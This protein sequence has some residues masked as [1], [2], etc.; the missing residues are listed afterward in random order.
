[1]DEAIALYQ[2]AARAGLEW[3]GLAAVFVVLSIR[4][5]RTDVAQGLLPA[6]FQW[7]RLK[8]WA[9]LL[10]IF[11]AA[12]GSAWVTALIGG[13]APKAALLAAL[14]VGLA[15]IGGHKVTK[16]AGHAHTQSQLRKNLNYEPGSIRTSIAPLLPIDQ[17]SLRRANQV[18]K[19]AHRRET[20][21]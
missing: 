18:S 21:G 10:I 17:N 15:A 1:M 6:V 2:E 3:W 19:T 13:A 5:L 12:L 8:R 14:P 7:H 20:R 9:Q 11:A 4:A 16:A